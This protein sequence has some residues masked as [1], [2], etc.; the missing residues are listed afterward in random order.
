MPEAQQGLQ[1]LL[2]TKFK[3]VDPY[4]EVSSKEMFSNC[5]TCGFPFLDA[6]DLFCGGCGTKLDDCKFFGTEVDDYQ[7]FGKQV[8]KT[9]LI[10]EI[11]E[12]ITSTKVKK[13]CSGMHESQ[14]MFD[15]VHSRLAD[16]ERQLANN[17]RSSSESF[18][19]H[20]QTLDRVYAFLICNVV[21]NH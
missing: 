9:K 6:N 3:Q 16:I 12:V 8:S 20:Q 1:R 4:A 19:E 7:F 15:R 13:I 21:T 2:Q 10:D 18:K 14:P 11:R 5:T 17:D